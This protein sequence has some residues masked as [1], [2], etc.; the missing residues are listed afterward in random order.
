MGGGPWA[1]SEA[2]ALMDD[3]LY[4]VMSPELWRTAGRPSRPADLRAAK[5]L[6]DRDPNAGWLAWR[7]AYGPADLDVR[8]GPRFSSSDVVL[9]AAAQGLGVALARGRLAADD[10]E[11]GTLVRPIAGSAVSLEHAYWVVMPTGAPRRE[12]VAVVIAW[13]EREARRQSLPS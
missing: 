11:A 10:L 9:R 3:C 12:A 2:H 7:E 6:H 1:G 8:R 13:L 5:L 4:P